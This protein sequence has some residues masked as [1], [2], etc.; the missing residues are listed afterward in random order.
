MAKL[1][2]PTTATL[3]KTVNA[4]HL[5]YNHEHKL[6]TDELDAF[7]YD[8]NDEKVVPAEEIDFIVGRIMQPTLSSYKGRQFCRK[9]PEY[10]DEVKIRENLPLVSGL[11]RSRNVNEITE[12]LYRK[13]NHG[14]T[15]QATPI[16][17]F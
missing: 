5:C 10:I 12:R 9:L 8:Y 1:R 14:C 7:D 6:N 15:P 17:S 3:A 13:R 11:G 16:T 2:R 4:C